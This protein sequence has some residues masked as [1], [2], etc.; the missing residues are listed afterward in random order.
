MAI[1]TVSWHPC[2]GRDC[3]KKKYIV[4]HACSDNWNLVLSVFGKE[5]P[6]PD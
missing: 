2:D 3:V 6:E 1:D 5:L 4:I